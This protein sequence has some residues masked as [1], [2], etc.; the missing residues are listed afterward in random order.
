MHNSFLK[1]EQNIPIKTVTKSR[2]VV[3]NIFRVTDPLMIWL[4]AVDPL[5]NSVDTITCN[6]FLLE[7]AIIHFACQKSQIFHETYLVIN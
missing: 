1:N 2:A 3:P 4:E 5:N 6:C 7:K